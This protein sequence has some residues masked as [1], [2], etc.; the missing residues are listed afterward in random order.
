MRLADMNE[1]DLQEEIAQRRGELA[2]LQDRVAVLKATAESKRQLR[3]AILAIKAEHD[4]LKKELCELK[5][6][7]GENSLK[8]AASFKK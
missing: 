7:E 8:F 1:Q 5:Q 6:H 2:V 4:A 3:E